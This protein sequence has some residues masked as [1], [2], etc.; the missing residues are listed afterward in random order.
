MSGTRYSGS[1]AET[2]ADFGT[3]REGRAARWLAEIQAARRECQQWWERSRAVIDRYRD[4]G[5]GRRGFGSEP[6][7]GS[8]MNILWSNV[9]TLAPAVY[10]STPQPVVQRRYGDE[11]DVA[12]VASTILQRV[13]AYELTGENDFDQIAR[14]CV[15]DNLLA[16]RGTVWLRY[17]PHFD[18][19]PPD[20]ASLLPQSLPAQAPL[21]QSGPP[22]VPALGMA[23]PIPVPAQPSPEISPPPQA[24]LSPAASTT[25][26]DP[27]GGGSMPVP[28]SVPFQPD[29]SSQPPLAPPLGPLPIGTM[30]DQRQPGAAGPGEPKDGGVQIAD[31]GEQDA[32][33][34]A[35]E[36]VAID[37][38]GVE[39]F[40]TN[41]ART[42]AEVKWVARRVYLTKDELAVRFGQALADEVPLDWRPSDLDQADPLQ[43]E[44][45][46][47]ARAQIYEIWDKPSRKVFWLAYG[48]PDR[49]L[50]ERD[51]PLG[52]PDFFP[53]PRPLYATLT[54]DTLVPVPDYHEY[55][56]Q[57]AEID[58]LTARISAVTR[59]I[60][61]AGVYDAAQE[62]IQRM[63]QEGVEN[64]L[65]P[66]NQWGAFAE[67]GGLKGCM[68]L[69]DIG[70][71][72]EVLAKL[73]ETR[74]QAKQDLYEVT[75]ISDIIRGSTMASET[76]T[77]QQIKSQFG[78]MRL[79][80]RQAEVARFCRDIIRIT[81]EIIC[82]QFHPRTLLAIS[83]IEQQP[84]VDAQYAKP[85]VM[86]LKDDKTRPLRID[87]ETDSTIMIDQQSEQQGRVQFLQMASQFLQ[88]ALPATQQYPMIAPLLGQMLLFGIRAFPQGAE[89]EGA[90]ETAIKA[91]QQMP[92]P[93]TQPDPKLMLA[94]AQV[95][96][97]DSEIANR[98]ID[99]QRDNAEAAAKLHLEGAKIGV[100]QQKAD[101]A[102]SEGALRLIHDHATEHRNAVLEAAKIRVAAQ[103]QAAAV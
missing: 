29:F 36:K 93:Q 5:P 11:D 45:Q 91:M 8:R 56:D 33:Y 84:G 88:Q 81:G 101:D 51:D 95:R 64:Q 41:P 90:F 72:S 63:F 61:I 50:D 32:Q 48:Y 3:D 16:G 43:P 37:H 44:H 96:N 27:T 66:V 53:C 58:N 31:D 24:Q 28:P 23:G 21:P 18:K 79:R 100:Q 38:V 22:P 99:N 26:I 69:L 89:L 54:T 20:I 2:P 57:A 35:W 39:D 65:I 15:L 49:C 10:A 71:L 102:A 62:G 59:T 83:D 94:Q 70:T 42:W 13:I 103:K 80:S 76:A 97:I 86:L 67:Q 12:R 19:S 74:A 25:P 1:G 47:F 6:T 9:Q 68:D 30:F 52:L 60:K 17:E 75:G 4:E 7:L 73:V 40:L 55:R 85:A 82:E 87:I 77:A 14:E 78:T 92:P 98:Q 46:L 34:L